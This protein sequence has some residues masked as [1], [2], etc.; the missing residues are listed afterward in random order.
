MM[1]TAR[2]QLGL[3]G[4]LLTLNALC[5]FIPFVLGLQ[6]QFV[7]NREISIPTTSYPPWFLGLANA[8]LVLVLYG[9]LGIAGLWFARKLELPGVFRE[10]A[11]WQRWIIQ[12]MRIGGVVGLLIILID[13][14]FASTESWDGF[15]HPPFPMSLI[16]SFAAG[17]G[18]E[19]L[20]RMFVMGL[21]AFL[22]YLL[23]RRWSIPKSV[24][25]WVGNVIGALVF[26]AGHLPSVMFLLHVKTP[27]EIPPVVL[28]ELV[29]LNGLVGLV[30]GERYIKDGLIAAAGVHFWTDIVWHVLWPLTFGA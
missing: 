11:G 7:P 10:G 15:E 22:I 20:F 30:A 28:I 5:V 23:L 4:V 26:T 9:L 29:L 18:E 3:F 14:I 2:R 8:G 6:N 12:P 1:V 16:A 24:A 13:R 19:I 21:W 17:I 25:L 27:A